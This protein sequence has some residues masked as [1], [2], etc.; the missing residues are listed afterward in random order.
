MTRRPPDLER[1]RHMEN[2]LLRSADL[3]DQVGGDVE[4]LQWHQRAVHEPGVVAGLT[5]EWTLST[6]RLTVSPGIGYDGRGR[7]V[8]LRSAAETPAPAVEEL[9]ALVIS[10]GP[11]GREGVLAWRPYRT[12]EACDGIPLAY[13]DE[14]RGPPRPSRA[15][16]RMAG[17]AP[18]VAAGETPPEATA[19]GPWM[20][21]FGR[22]AFGIQ[23]RVDT[24]AAGFTEVPCYFA[25]LNWPSPEAG[26]PET[27]AY[28]FLGFQH[29]RDESVGSFLFRVYMPLAARIDA[30]V[31]LARR[32][33][34]SVCWLG[35]E[36]EHHTQ[37][38]RRRGHVAVR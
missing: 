13:V 10:A 21:D 35:I 26:L 7:E 34:L 8:L 20:N 37:A 14:K 17:Q 11:P 16:A 31:A 33:R 5:V 32:E 15:P 6:R 3:R 23:V 25:W 9:T 1:I 4:L 38:T 2:E 22:T 18:R 36:G 24:S 30:E 27:T 19:W 29:L 28:F 12:L